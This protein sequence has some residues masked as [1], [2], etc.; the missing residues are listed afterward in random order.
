MTAE[1]LYFNSSQSI[2]FGTARLHGTAVPKTPKKQ[3]C[4]SQAVLARC[5]AAQLSLWV[6]SAAEDVSFCLNLIATMLPMPGSQALQFSQ[7][8]RSHFQRMAFVVKYTCCGEL[9]IGMWGCVTPVGILLWT[10]TRKKE[11]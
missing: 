1:L 5:R 3:P 4:A 7:K 9:I 2:T 11:V 6:V 10:T 8:K